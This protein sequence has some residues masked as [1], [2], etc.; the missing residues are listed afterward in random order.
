MYTI[1]LAISPGRTL[2][3]PHFHGAAEPREPRFA[4]IENEFGA[5]PIDNELLAN[6]VPKSSSAW[7]GMGIVGYRDG[8]GT[9]IY[10]YSRILIS[11]GRPPPLNNFGIQN[12]V[13]KPRGRVHNSVEIQK[14]KI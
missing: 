8:M 7:D 11:V 4:V 12:S 9:C 2:P 1:N 5:V 14:K 6:S 10:I 13:E 3:S